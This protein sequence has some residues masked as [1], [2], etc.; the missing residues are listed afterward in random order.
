M[1][2][3]IVR[4]TNFTV[5]NINILF[6]ED[7]D[8][9][10]GI[11]NVSL[12]S[13]VS[14]VSDP[15]IISL[16]IDND[17][18]NLTFSPLFPNIKY[19][20]Q[21]S[22]TPSVLF[23]ATSGEVITEDGNRNAI[24]IV[25]PGEISDNIRESMM[26]DLSPTVYETSEPTLIRDLV[27]GM[28][29][30]F[31]KLSDS[32]E[33]ARSGNY[34]S[35]LVT[36]ELV[37]RGDGPTDKL[38]KQGAFE[39]LKVSPTISGSS[40]PGFLEFGFSRKQFFDSRDGIYLN[41]IIETLTSDPISLQAEDV[42]NETVTDDINLNNHFSGLKIKLEN[43]NV[44]QVISV[45]LVRNSSYTEYNISAY[46]YTLLDNRYDTLLAGINVNL[47]SNE[48]ELSSK[49][50][51]GGAGGFII[52]EAGDQ[53]KI[54]YV[55]KNLGRNITSGSVSLT[56]TKT[57][58][59]EICPAITNR[60]STLN[61]PI[62]NNFDEIST[63]GGVTFLCTQS[64]SSLDAFISNHPAFNREIKFDISRL[65]S[66]PGEFSVNY[67]TGEINVFGEDQ[68]NDGTGVAPPAINY[69]Y[70]KI[71]L[72]N[73]DFVFD[74]DTSE[75]AIN[76]TRNI[77]GIEAKISFE[78]EDVFADGSDFVALSHIESLNERVENRLVSDFMLS[79][80]KYP[81]TNVFRI[82][83]E[84]T[85]E[86]YN[87]TRFNDST[88]TFSGR[89][90][91]RQIDVK[92][93][94]AYFDS[95]S[96]EVLLVSDELTNTTNLRV[97]KISLSNGGL[98][99]GRGR[100]IGANFNTSVIF[101]NNDIFV[102]EFFYEDRIYNDIDT[103]LDKLTSV[104]DYIVDYINGVVYVSVSSDQD[105]DIGEIKYKY[106]NIKTNKEHILNVFDV[107]RS[108]SSLSSN[109]KNYNFTNILDGT[110]TVS[111]LE[112]V[113]Q[114]FID[115]DSSRPLIV[116]VSQ[117]GNDGIFSLGRNIFTSN[118]ATFTS[119]DVGKI[120]TVGSNNDLP[121]DSFTV[122]MIVNSHQIIVD[123]NFT[124]GKN[125]APWSLVYSDQASPKTL[126]LDF[127]A[128]SVKAIYKTSE[129]ET[130]PFSSLTNYF[131]INTDFIEDNI[132]TLDAYN[133][134]QNGDSVLIDYNYGD[135]FVDYV[136]LGDEIL[137]SYEYG[138]N[139]LNWS[140]SSS[141][142]VGS[143]YYVTYKYGAL[144]DSL[145]SNFGSLTQ[146]PQLT[147]F[148]LDLNRETYRS[149]LGGTLQSFITGPTIPSIEGLVESFTE[150][151][152]NIK[153][154]IVGWILGES[155]LNI[156]APTYNSSKTFDF[157]K[158]N[159]GLRVSDNQYVEVQAPS[160]LKINEGTIETWIRPSW[161]GIEN[162]STLTFDLSMDGYSDA[163]N[164]YI[165][166]L[167]ENPSTN[168]FTLKIDSNNIFELNFPSE[169]SDKTGFFIW[170]DG[171][172]GLWQI[173]WR[174]N[175]A[176]SHVFSGTISTTGEFFNISVPVEN[177]SNINEVTDVITSTEKEI[178]F[179]ASIDGYD[180]ATDDYGLSIDGVSFSS[181][182][183]HYIFDMAHG[184][185]SN[186][187][188]L[189][190]DG[191]GFINF[192][193]FDN[194]SLFGLSS[195]FYNLSSDVSDWLSE[196]L[197]HIAVSWKFNSPDEKDEMHLFI[198]GFEAPNLFKYGGKPDFVNDSSMFGDVAEEI[199][200]ASAPKSI[201]G[202]FDGFSTAGSNIF[203]SL[204]SDFVASGISVGDLLY[205]LDET[206]DGTEFP[207]EGDPYTITGV[208]EHSVE[209]SSSLSLSLGN[210]HFSINQYSVSVDTPIDIQRFVVVK[211][212]AYGNETEINGLNSD[213]PDYSILSGSNFS[214]TIYLN[215]NIDEGS[216]VVLKT[217]GLIFKRFLDKIYVYG[218]GYDT[219]RTNSSPPTDLSDV[220][221]TEIILDGYNI[222]VD[223][224]F[225]ISG[226]N[227]ERFLNIYCQPSNNTR[228]RT[229][230]ITLLGENI[231]YGVGPNQ[232]I[233]SG[234]TY[235]GATTE[236]INFSEN[237]TQ[238]TDEYWTS[239]S[240]VFVGVTPTN[241]VIAD[242]SLSAG[243]I[244]IREKDSITVSNNSGDCAEV[245]QYS[246]G[247]FR[248]EIYGSAG[249]P[250]VLN[251]CLYE[252]DYTSYL[253]INIDSLPE[254]F[255][256][257]SD[258]AG[259]NILNSVIDEFRILDYMS[260]DTR[261][262]ES[263]GSLP[264]TITTD[265]M[266]NFAF[267]EDNNTLL[268]MHFDGSG[269]DSSKFIDKFNSGFEVAQS[270]NDSFD[271]G[272]KLANNRPYIIDNAGFIFNNNE[273]SLEFWMSP[274]EDMN[275]NP[276]YH[277]YFDAS[278]I[279]QDVSES[280][281]ATTVTSNQKIRTIDSVRLVSDTYNS[282]INYFVG[283]RVSNI[284][285]KTITLGIPL[286]AQNIGVKIT[287]VPMSN[288]G[289]RVSVF[290]D[291]FGFI[292][293][294][295]KASN[296][297]YL[298]SS[299]VN[300]N[301][302]TWHRIMVMWK[303]NSENNL[304]RMRLFVDGSESGTIKYGTGLLYG[305]GVI[306]GQAEIRAGTDRFLV[307][308]IDLTDT[309]SQIYIGTDVFSAN[310]ANAILD[311]IRFSDI[312][313]LQLIRTTTTDIID[314]GFQQNTDF[315]IPTVGDL[316]T[317]A[318]YNFDSIPFEITSATTLVN[319]KNG[320]F[321]FEVE[322]IDSLDK[323][324]GNPD[325]ENL[326]ITLINVIKPASCTAIIKFR[327]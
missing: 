196:Q 251:G 14:S 82:F 98:T 60:Y 259:Q 168:P 126:V 66:R 162:D 61:A 316:N 282:G 223:N 246:N 306:Y 281:T 244:E 257:G 160:H 164:I 288:N 299:Y 100:F 1:A 105:L 247:I 294:Y 89:R 18:I 159:Q 95:V 317:T 176:E 74:G 273:G 34:L 138:N 169:M 315:A 57:I 189:F 309:F 225:V 236:T 167:G 19:F 59:R 280:I 237:G 45:A 25:S 134:L 47:N 308:N 153:E 141:L 9:S 161:N 274:L 13:S 250:F 17:N 278:S 148:S 69:L 5:S 319:P 275:N 78:F 261:V 64:T 76:S 178:N 214:Y 137:V 279:V 270:V 263:L 245:S 180:V 179:N 297:E 51:T 157:G 254:M 128:I 109:I 313:R 79:T 218:G 298:L 140:V 12:T 287:Y 199:L 195:G 215:N 71:F 264:R 24:F 239:I 248:L 41:P 26:D 151:K 200:S 120:L 256:I 213:S 108:S 30:Q 65:P 166:F 171:V 271:K 118:S 8:T 198:D 222:S 208:G 314:A 93:E 232:V 88:V 122:T 322:V 94:K 305:N 177:S 43:K 243:V 260:T 49:S 212:D 255:Y 115:D 185:S 190:K 99:D 104:G 226:P 73:L 303:T 117:D 142:P 325:L 312:Q 55:Y 193:V 295:I 136:Y 209:V 277:Y 23:R 135:L 31:H 96:Q 102:N 85:G 4:I 252:I 324:I 147:T 33:I 112:E 90:A 46:G 97:F 84:T 304:D 163:S 6:N 72:E 235:S 7:I 170:F 133:L 28:S 127:N 175:P 284:D 276:N 241:D 224:D 156:K 216:R 68:N 103:N 310:G 234:T 262:G 221:I 149:I 293:F 146:I 27:S 121:I 229:L 87:I 11:D 131:D 172:S 266:Y 231:D 205:I 80:K 155:N 201:V 323:V 320:I 220:K 40:R 144:R 2:F 182:D 75:L 29:S 36:D 174:Q 187:M 10:V 184:Q 86:V 272:I 113:G 207:N 158:F 286:P 32:A 210:I 242:T 70:R 327:K 301:R 15:D 253:K 249:Q 116:G 230:A 125:G 233:I 258:F 150:V 62:I 152:P 81:I 67:N 106:K 191:K 188:S 173:R 321:K 44:M 228:G 300:W 92:R 16:I 194:K 289:D 91:P 211:Q 296:I 20:L 124:L 54:S 143:Q 35:V 326:L 181:G 238:Y 307:D 268:L 145:L 139:S 48:V 39:I 217:L 197:H 283:G 77:S 50:I 3:S 22:S 129:L 58:A 202:G 186:R 56:T 154:N 291:E 292:N 101:S 83:N 130:L 311:N 110:V 42:V 204:G 203:S 107:Y 219:I 114:K 206:P 302:H 53:I 21:F 52:P 240:N 192:R 123:Q 119:D 111:N 183:S 132:V 265:F 227:M 37:T 285:G 165:G 38:S 318:L 63:A 290:A 269:D 267:T